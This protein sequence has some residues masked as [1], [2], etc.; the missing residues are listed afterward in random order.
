MKGSDDQWDGCDV[1]LCV[2]ELQLSKNGWLKLGR[3]ERA[4]AGKIAKK[5]GRWGRRSR[6]VEGS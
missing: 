5:D 3:R 1:A 4:G 2:P 6:K